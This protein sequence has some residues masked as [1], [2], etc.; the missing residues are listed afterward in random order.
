[1]VPETQYDMKAG[2][3]SKACVFLTHT[4]THTLAH[5][6]ARM[7]L[8]QKHMQYCLKTHTAFAKLEFL[9]SN[10]YFIISNILI[11]VSYTYTHLHTTHITYYYII[12]TTIYITE[13]LNSDLSKAV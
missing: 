7:C 8:T 10:I 4:H 6:C 1:M 11:Y 9:V 2:W 3:N 5:I 12:Y 13:F